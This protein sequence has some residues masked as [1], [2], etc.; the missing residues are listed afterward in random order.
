MSNKY[1]RLFEGRDR[2]V[3]TGSNGGEIVITY[4][5]EPA[6]AAPIAICELLGGV[7]GNAGDSHRI[8]P[9]SD[10]QFPNF[11]CVEAREKPM[12]SR[13]VTNAPA[14]SNATHEPDDQSTI[15][16]ALE[17]AL[18]FDG[19][20]SLNA[21][22]NYIPLPQAQDDRGRCGAYIEAVYR[23]LYSVYKF[24]E[25]VG[26]Q[27]FINSFDYVDPQF[28]PCSRTYPYGSHFNITRGRPSIT[29]PG[30]TVT[31]TLHDF[32]SQGVI[33]E[34]WREFTIRRLMC[35]SVPWQTIESLE[36][37]VNIN[38][39]WKPAHFLID[40][41]AANTFAKGVVR[42]DT[43]DVIPRLVYSHFDSN[44]NPVFTSQG[45]PQTVPFRCYDIVLKFSIRTTVGVW[46]DDS[47]NLQPVTDTGQKEGSIPWIADWNETETTTG[48]IVG[49]DQSVTFRIGWYIP[50]YFGTKPT[51]PNAAI[52]AYKYFDAGDTDLPINQPGVLAA[53]DCSY[54]FDALFVEGAP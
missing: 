16:D 21:E 19:P 11:Y 48:P 54:A 14:M 17:N 39:K 45:L 30:S 42:F 37:R 7:T 32:K 1:V 51:D 36:N 2:V 23:P 44:G 43:A 6:S 41:L 20:S 46:Y 13:A 9:D 24:P 27:D 31:Q 33:T 50:W 38:T 25:S 47:G 18:I 5:V 52:H 28:V 26:A 8:I 4:Y 40:G 29:S 35:P 53:L 22:G 12:D 49:I 34:T 10:S 15:S 3:R